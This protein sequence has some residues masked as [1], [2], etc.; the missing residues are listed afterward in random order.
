[1]LTGLIPSRRPT[2]NLV[3]TSGRQLGISGA[4]QSV[5]DMIYTVNSILPSPCHD[6]TFLLYQFEV[7]NQILKVEKICRLKREDFYIC[8]AG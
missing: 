5:A 2:V 1:M 7:V 3:S 4:F 8:I 6:V